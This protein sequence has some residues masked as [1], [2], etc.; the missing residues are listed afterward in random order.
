MK[1]KL[2]FLSFISIIALQSCIKDNE[3]PVAVAPFEGAVINPN[4]GGA[5]QPNQ[6]WIN[7]SSGTEVTNLRTKWDLAFYSGNEYKVSL[8]SSIQM[9]AGE[10]PNVQNIDNVTSASVSALLG[11]VQVG[12]FNPTNEKYIDEVTG[13]VPTERTAIKT[14]SATDSENPVYLINLGKEIYKGNVP[15]GTVTYAGNPRGWMKVQITRS[16]KNYKLKYAQLDDKTHKEVVIEKNTDYNFSFFSL[17]NN[18]EVLVQPERKKWDIAFTVFTNIIEGAGSYAYA[19]YVV[20][21]ILGNVGVYQV[22]IPKEQKVS[23]VYNAFKAKD[24]E[25]AK[26]VIN[27]QR[28]IGAEWRNPVGANGLEVYGDRF[29]VIKDA[30]GLY[31]KLKFNRMTS[32]Q[33][34]RGYP[35]F[36]YKP[37]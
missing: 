20:H 7:L 25:P 35:Q 23:E 26:F 21:N 27:D 34:E 15:V 5:T 24:V 9:A 19:D 13:N 2:L 37:L 36:E 18:E 29:F 10:I 31:Y 4:V 14:I 32:V 12:T 8:N 17:V 16:G 11:V 3:D 1:T 6:V 33:G 22:T 28:T 30:N